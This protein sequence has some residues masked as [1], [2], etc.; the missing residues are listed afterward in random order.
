MKV[1]KMLITN[2][3]LYVS[4]KYLEID[5]QKH[6]TV[7]IRQGLHFLKKIIDHCTMCGGPNVEKLH[8]IV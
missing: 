4:S 5:Q 8:D 1:F 2:M 7:E 6:S 3:H